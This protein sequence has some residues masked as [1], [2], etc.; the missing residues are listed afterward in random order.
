MLCLS[1][2]LSMG[3]NIGLSVGN[4]GA[5]GSWQS[6]HAFLDC[7]PRERSQ[8]PFIPPCAPCLNA[9]ACGLWHW[10][11]RSMTLGYLMA[12]LSASLSVS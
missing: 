12:V 2:N 1:R 6:I 7:G 11:Q 3:L 9:V 5:C 4:W 10:A 8:K